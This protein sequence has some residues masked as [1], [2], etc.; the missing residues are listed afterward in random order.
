MPLISLAFENRKLLPPRDLLFCLSTCMP[1][2]DD[3]PPNKP[4]M[5]ITIGVII[6]R[7]TQEQLAYKRTK[8]KI[9]NAIHALQVSF[10]IFQDSK[11]VLEK[12]TI[13]VIERRIS[14]EN[15]FHA[16][17]AACELGRQG[18]SAYVVIA[19]CSVTVTVRKFAESLKLPVMV[20]HTT[21]CNIQ[22]STVLS[23]EQTIAMSRKKQAS[24]LVKYG[25]YWFGIGSE[26]TRTINE[27]IAALVSYEG[28]NKILFYTDSNQW[29]SVNNF[30]SNNGYCVDGFVVQNLPLSIYDEIDEQAFI[31]QFKSSPWSAADYRQDTLIILFVPLVHAISS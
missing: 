21:E 9:D 26:Y 13:K 24:E 1:P 14:P 16:V 2:S 5:S 28:I 31:Q 6:E 25:K 7:E 17:Q 22:T 11:F 15:V 29:P 12:T 19:S 4:P 27:A 10:D 30:A 20:V 3:S 18:I 23:L 8:F